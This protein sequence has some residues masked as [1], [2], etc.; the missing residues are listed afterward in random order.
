MVF[1]ELDP[2]PEK[3]KSLRE[4]E[5]CEF[6]NQFVIFIQF[7]KQDALPNLEDIFR[8]EE[9]DWILSVTAKKRNS[10]NESYEGK[11]IVDFVTRTGYIDIN[12]EVDEEDK[13]L[14]RRT[15]PLHR[16]TRDKCLSLEV[17]PNLFKM[18]NNFEV[19]YTDEFGLTHFHIAC[20]HNYGC[21]DIVEKFLELSQVD[22]NLLVPKTGDTPL[23]LALKNRKKATFELLLRRDADPE[24]TNEAG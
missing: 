5:R 1:I 14:P 23:H 21:Y 6:L 22:P 9:I 19:N 8:R 20:Q 12:F 13:P 3:L 4:K 17:I 15:T 11:Q 2:D 7:W 10:V 24:S 18:Y 16:A